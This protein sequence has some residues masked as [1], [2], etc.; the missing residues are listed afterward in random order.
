M[1]IPPDE[2]PEASPGP[3]PRKRRE[4]VRAVLAEATQLLGAVTDTARLDAELLMAHALG[5][6]RNVVRTHLKNLGLI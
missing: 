3:S 6:T 2:S 4:G 1:T 5:V